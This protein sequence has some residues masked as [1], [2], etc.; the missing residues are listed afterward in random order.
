MTLSGVDH[1]LD[2]KQRLVRGVW[3]PV[4]EGVRETA[5][6]S[7]DGGK[8]WRLWFDIWFRTHGR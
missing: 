2:G 5:M 3:K 7:Y 4:R 8:T 6:T 1:M